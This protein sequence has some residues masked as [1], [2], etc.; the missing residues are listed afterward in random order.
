MRLISSTFEHNGSIPSKYT[1]D[2]ENINP[3]LIIGDVPSTT[4]SLV[5]LMIDPDISES[6]KKMHNIEVWDHWI[7]FNIPP[8]I[9]EIK[10][11][12]KPK[13]LVGKNTRGNVSYGGPCPQIKNIAISLWCML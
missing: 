12:E 1:C 5:L 3:P 8:T 13:G 2:G 4:K 6:A 11:N 9:K 7:V 10:E